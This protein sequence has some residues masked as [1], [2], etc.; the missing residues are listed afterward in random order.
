MLTWVEHKDIIKHFS[1][2]R[3]YTFAIEGYEV[4]GSCSLKVYGVVNYGTPIFQST[5][6]SFKAAKYAANQIASEG[7]N[8]EPKANPKTHFPVS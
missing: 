3:D 5:Y 4:R 7:L 6:S 8:I 1:T 2:C